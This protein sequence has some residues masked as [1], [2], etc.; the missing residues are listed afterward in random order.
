MLKPAF[1]L[2]PLMFTP[3]ELEALVLGARWGG[4]Q[5]VDGVGLAAQSALAACA[6][7]SHDDRHARSHDTGLWPV[8]VWS[9]D[10]RRSMPILGQ[11]RQAMRTEKALQIAYEDEGGNP[12]ERAIWPVQLAYYEGKQV[13]AAW[14][15]LRT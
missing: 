11:V 3:G 1:V 6:T 4:A 7:A 10:S 5:P 2:P 14:C 12:S 8:A 9:A 15:C 13:I